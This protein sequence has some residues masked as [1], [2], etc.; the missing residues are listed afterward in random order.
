MPLLCP[1]QVRLMVVDFYAPSFSFRN[2]GVPRKFCPEIGGI[3][4]P[5]FYS[6]YCLP[7]FCSVAESVPVIFSNS[8]T[9]PHGPIRFILL[10]KVFP[11]GLRSNRQSFLPVQ[12]FISVNFFW[13]AN[14]LSL[15]LAASIKSRSRA[16]FSISFLIETI[17][18]S[19][20]G[21]VLYSSC[22][23]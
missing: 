16:A 13:R 8:R 22:S 19:T 1:G 17:A 10:F 20:C 11:S 14:M 15:S 3:C 21:M 2:K 5:Y 9:K 4:D 18:F 7:H 12:F 6:T 23:S